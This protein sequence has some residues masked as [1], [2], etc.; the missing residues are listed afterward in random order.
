MKTVPF[1][2]ILGQVCQLVGLDRN[3]LNDKSFAAVRDMCSRRLGSIWDREEWPDTERRLTTWAGNPVESIEVLIQPILNEYGVD[4]TTEDSIDVLTESALGNNLRVYLDVNFPRVYVAKFEGDAYRKNT[5]SDTLIK[6][7]NPFYI[8]QEDGTRISVSEKQYNFTYSTLTDSYGD[9]IRYIEI[10]IPSGIPEY[11]DVYQGPNA[12]LTTTVVF[13]SNK[14]LLVQ[15]GTG[16]LQ[17]L[18]VYGT[19]PRLSTRTVNESF[20]V[21]DFF[22]RNDGDYD[23]IWQQE[24]SYLRFLTDNQKFIKYRQTC[25][26]LF[27]SKFSEYLDY[28]SGSQVYYDTAQNNGAY[29]PTVLTNAVRGNFWIATQNVPHTLGVRPAEV[30]VYWKMISIPYRFKDYL[31]NGIAADFLR[32]EG[33]A[34]EAGV[35]DGTAEIALQQQI[36]V[37][38]RQQ[39]QVQR[40]NMVYSY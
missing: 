39:G 9:Y 17:G 32:S 10:T 28:L 27:G 6:F 13:T 38:V 19:D 5:I 33:R 7:L 3:T 12:P 20:L 29:N 36:D 22:D 35:L 14:N 15:L 24:F 30:S 2:D 1:S 37:L 18:E 8:L 40:M 26:S 16:A 4:I 11:P 31:I 21:E 25:S 34:E 23:D